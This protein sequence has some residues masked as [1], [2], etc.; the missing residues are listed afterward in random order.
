MVF[1]I[2]V[3]MHIHEFQAKTLFSQYSIE[4]LK[5]ALIEKTDKVKQACE[6][7]GGSVWVVK[8]QVHAGGRGKGGGVIVCQTIEAVQNACDKLLNSYLITPQT[9]DKGLLVK[10]VLIEQGVDIQRELYLSFLID[11]QTQ[12]VMILASTEGGMNIEEVAKNSPEKIINL[13][14]NC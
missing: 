6:T 11:R 4:T 14:E 3:K 2:M 7:I 13:H 8:A 5:S 1:I 9:T 12:S 10:Q